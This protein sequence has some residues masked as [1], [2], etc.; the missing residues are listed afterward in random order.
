MISRS[1]RVAAARGG[2]GG[3]GDVTGEKWLAAGIVVVAA[4]VRSAGLTLDRAWTGVVDYDDGVYLLSAQRLAHGDLPYRGLRVRASAGVLLVLQPSAWLA[5]VVSGPAVLA[6]ARVL[7]VLL[8]CLNTALVWRPAAG[9]RASR[10][11]RRCW[12][13]RNVVR[14]RLG[15]EDRPAGAPA[16]LGLSRRSCCCGRHTPGASVVRGSCSPPRARSS[17]GSDRCSSPSWAGC[18][19]PR[20]ATCRAE[21]WSALSSAAPRSS[22]RSSSR[23]PAQMWEQTVT[24]QAVTTPGGVVAAAPPVPG[25]LARDS[26]LQAL[27]PSFVV[28]AAGILV[29]AL[30]FRQLVRGG[31]RALLAVLL[32]VGTGSCSQHELLLHYAGFIGVPLG[33]PCSA[34]RSRTSAAHLGVRTPLVGGALVAALCLAWR[35]VAGNGRLRVTGARAPQRHR[36]GPG[37]SGRAADVL[38]L[39]D[40]GVDSNL[41]CRFEPDPRRRLVATDPQHDTLEELCQADGRSCGA[42][43]RRCWPTQVHHVSSGG[44]GR[45]CGRRRRAGWLSV[46][47]HRTCAGRPDVRRSGR[48]SGVGSRGRTGRRGTRRASR[49]KRRRTRGGG[50]GATYGSGDRRVTSSQ[51][52]ARPHPEGLRYSG[53]GAAGRRTTHAATTT[54]IAR[55]HHRQSGEGQLAGAEAEQESSPGEGVAEPGH[56]DVRTGPDL[57]LEQRVSVV[58][59]PAPQVRLV[60][61]SAQR[62]HREQQRSTRTQRVEQ[63]V[64]RGAGSGTRWSVWVTTAASYAQDGRLPG[65]HRSARRRR[66]GSSRRCRRPARGRRRACS[67]TRPP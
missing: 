61:H 49:E 54:G 6:A 22:S 17:S 57:A 55:V 67:R 5:D 24:A 38:Y 23:R 45:W 39:A 1:G 65:W 42:P 33:R 10:P 9:L 60:D 44:S 53:G 18:S 46:A 3:S 56:R 28:V 58:R 25:R 14:H 19:S 4:A 8:G 26:Q 11:P 66:A 52:P 43:R 63:R 16:N 64:Q 20:P 47:G 15:R 2:P 31:E 62:R 7:V 59:R 32:L 30:A 40:A 37:A 12:V 29:L 41:A 13:L 27:V 36:S 50:T 21:P 48:P 34:S 35:A 51:D